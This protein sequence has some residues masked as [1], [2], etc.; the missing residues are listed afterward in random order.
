MLKSLINK[1]NAFKEKLK[2]KTKEIFKKI[3]KTSIN[4]KKPNNCSIVKVNYGSN[5]IFNILED[6]EINF[7]KIDKELLINK[8]V[9]ICSTIKDSNFK[10]TRLITISKKSTVIKNKEDYKNFIINAKVEIIEF[11]KKMQEN[12]EDVEIIEII[13]KVINIINE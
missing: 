9:I 13:F 3:F 4:E 5:I 7:S 8:S 11:F 2:N 1:L 12:Y 10:Y 6:N